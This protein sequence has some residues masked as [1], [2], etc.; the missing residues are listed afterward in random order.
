MGVPEVSR[1]KRLR[2]GQGEAVDILVAKTQSLLRRLEESTATRRLH[3]AVGQAAMRH[4]QLRTV[5][6]R[7]FYHGLITGYRVAMKVVQGKVGR[8]E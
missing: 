6:N 3:R 8:N 5:G 1:S 2:I 7:G 4:R